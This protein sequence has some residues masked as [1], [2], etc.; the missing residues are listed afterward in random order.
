M[1]F[2]TLQ[3]IKD[4]ANTFNDAEFVSLINENTALI[5]SLRNNSVWAVKFD[6]NEDN[7]LTFDATES[8]CLQEGDSNAAAIYKQE[9]SDF[10]KSLIGMFAESEEDREE[11]KMSLKN[12]FE[13]SVPES[14]FFALKESEKQWSSDVDKSLVSEGV[15]PSV[16]KM[17]EKFSDKFAKRVETEKDLIEANSMFESTFEIK[18]EVFVDPI[19]ILECIEYNNKEES[20]EMSKIEAILSF[21][22]RLDE[23]YGQKIGNYI[24]ENIKHDSKLTTILKTLVTAKKTFGEEGEEKIGSVNEEAKNLAKILEE[25]F[26]ETYLEND[27]TASDK[28]NDVIYNKIQN[29]GRYRFLQYKTGIF[30]EGDLDEMINEFQSVKATYLN[31]MTRDDLMFINE[32]ES[33]IMYMQRT[34]NINDQVVSDVLSQFGQRF[35]RDQQGI[36]GDN[37]KLGFVSDSERFSRNFQFGTQKVA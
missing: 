18:K 17:A 12:I 11:A 7:V 13:N 28:P 4:S 25:S 37:G 21:K 15:I 34:H 16:A 23:S 36:V 9:S 8:E 30:S 14:E 29:P 5:K 27:F 3:R 6:I 35:V 20:K 22:Q 10:K 19:H 31:G 26:E 1:D 33:R 24:F 2:E 32:L